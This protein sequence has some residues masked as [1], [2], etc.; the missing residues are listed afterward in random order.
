M[1]CSSL[2]SSGSQPFLIHSNLKWYICRKP[3]LSFPRRHYFKL[4]TKSNF[5]RRRVSVLKFRIKISF[6]VFYSYIAFIYYLL[7]AN[8]Q[9]FN[10]TMRIFYKNTLFEEIIA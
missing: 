3:A 2:F 8:G 1:I 10:C 4:K 7:M 5:V 6:A 9:I